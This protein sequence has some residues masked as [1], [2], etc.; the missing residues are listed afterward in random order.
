V[1]SVEHISDIGGEEGDEA[2]VS[3]GGEG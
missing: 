2:P 3:E 1:V